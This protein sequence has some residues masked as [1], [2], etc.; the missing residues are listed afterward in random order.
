MADHPLPVVCTG[1]PP[2]RLDSAVHR[3]FALAVRLRRDRMADGA[4]APTPL[5]WLMERAEAGWAVP[6]NV[7][8][9]VVGASDNITTDRVRDERGR[10]TGA[11]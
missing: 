4:D 10:S 6:P 5:A 9:G 8:F 11:G 3:R 7:G 1:D 2:L